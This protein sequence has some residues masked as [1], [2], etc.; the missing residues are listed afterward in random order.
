MRLPRSSS[1]AHLI[2]PD[3]R[4][5]LLDHFC[6][7]HVWTNKASI[8]IQNIKFWNGGVQ[9]VS[10]KVVKVSPDSH[11][12]HMMFSRKVGLD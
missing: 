6:N 3:R 7:V 8:V 12:I 1:I 9:K 11:S 4:S 10:S 5:Y 2:L